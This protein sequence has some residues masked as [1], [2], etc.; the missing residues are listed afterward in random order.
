MSPHWRNQRQ[1]AD[2][3]S[4]RK[5]RIDRVAVAA[6]RGQ[7]DMRVKLAR[8]RARSSRWLERLELTMKT[9]NSKMKKLQ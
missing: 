4:K 6:A 9:E 2:F 3:G 1:V 5:F 7:I 8:S